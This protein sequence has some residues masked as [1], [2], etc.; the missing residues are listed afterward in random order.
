MIIDGIDVRGCKLS[1]KPF[2]PAPTTNHVSSALTPSEKSLLLNAASVSIQNNLYVTQIPKNLSESE[3]QR[4]FAMHGKT[5]SF[6]LICS[7]SYTTNIAY[8]AYV[9]ADHASKVFKI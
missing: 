6:K 2:Q 7:D 9:N 4:T 3:V 8:V 5:S 1:V